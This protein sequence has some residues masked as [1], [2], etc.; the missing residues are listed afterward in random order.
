MFQQRCFSWT[1]HLKSLK[2]SSIEKI[3]SLPKNPSI[4]AIEPTDPPDT[5]LFK[6]LLSL[7]EEYK[8]HT[9]LVQVGSFYEIYDLSKGNDRSSLVQLSESLGLQIGTFKTSMNKY[10]RIGFPSSQLQ[11]YLKKL[12]DMNL[13]VAV[14][15]QSDRDPASLKS[16][17]ERKVKR[18]VTPGTLVEEDEDRYQNSFLLTISILN[19]Q[20]G[21]SWW[22]VVTG[23]SFISTCSLPSLSMEVSV[24][25]PKEIL[26]DSRLK[27]DESLR[28]YFETLPLRVTFEESS[29]FNTESC[30]DIIQKSMLQSFHSQ[31]E[32]RAVAGLCRYIQK[33]FPEN[34][35]N[36]L[37][38]QST[39]T[40]DFLL[41]DASVLKSLEMTE[42]ESKKKMTLYKLLNKTMTLA[43]SR[44]LERR[45]SNLCEFNHA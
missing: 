2:I 1:R 12:I 8:N 10:E 43:G 27:E 28:T 7:Q 41:M 15:E 31:V 35:P 20:V 42:T 32:K 26:V 6:Q 37:P 21:L 3:Q 36:L 19:D 16:L 4:A 17:L 24:I 18:I 25:N 45:L 33:I 5:D 38:P 34:T 44:L 9:L 40:N 22:D 14:V 29:M 30:D 23:D 39:K 11:K 13:S